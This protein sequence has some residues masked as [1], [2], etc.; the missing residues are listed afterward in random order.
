MDGGDELESK[1]DSSSPLLLE[2]QF[3]TTVEHHFVPADRCYIHSLDM[4]NFQDSS[5]QV[6]I[7]LLGKSMR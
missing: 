6:V 1:D 4:Q 2:S 5:H 7:S 3:L